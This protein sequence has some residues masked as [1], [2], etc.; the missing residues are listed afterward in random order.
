M[1]KHLIITIDGTSSTG[2]STI[3]RRIADRFSCLYIDTGAMYRALTLYCIN[4]KII[5]KDFFNESSLIEKLNNIDI[6]FLQ[7]PKSKNLEIV[8]N[9]NFV[10]NKIRSMNI[11]KSSQAQPMQPMKQSSGM[12]AN[13][14]Q[15]NVGNHHPSPPSVQPHQSSGLH[16]QLK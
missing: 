4:N 5:S 15:Q 7:N 11:S 1:V 9:G 13:Q 6:N 10:E 16:E 3:A 2:K 8:L 12:N 14:N